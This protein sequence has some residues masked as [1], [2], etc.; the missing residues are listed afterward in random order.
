MKLQTAIVSIIIASV[1]K[2]LSV[3]LGREE[4]L[5]Y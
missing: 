3:Y 5:R 1:M 4:F 2:D